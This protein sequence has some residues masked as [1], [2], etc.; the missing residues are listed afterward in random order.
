SFKTTDFDIGFIS[1]EDGFGAIIVM[2]DKGFDAKSCGFTV[3]GN[4]LMRDS[5]T[6]KV[7]ERLLSFPERKSKI[8]M[9]SQT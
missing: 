8:H 1:R 6:V 2:I 7:M 9:H 3:V 4:A 5:D